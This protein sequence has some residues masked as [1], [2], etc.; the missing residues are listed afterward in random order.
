MVKKLTQ[1]YENYASS[2]KLFKMFSTLYYAPMVKKEICLGAV[3]R[4]SNVLF[5]GG[6]PLPM[7]ALLLKRFTGA[8]VSIVD[9]NLN[10]IT[11]AKNVIQES[12]VYIQVIH[13]YGQDVEVK[14]YDTI[15][16]AKQVVS[17]DVVFKHLINKANPK[18]K[19][20]LRHRLQ[21]HSLREWLSQATYQ[22]IDVYASSN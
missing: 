18:T 7:S 10:A 1:L 13:A 6:G 4:H 19:I 12:G 22:D 20:I 5:I 15:I 11:K 2:N 3:N 8:Q 17:Q 9:C 21:T 16:V 14:D